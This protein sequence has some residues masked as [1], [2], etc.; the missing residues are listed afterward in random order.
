M[1]CVCAH[2]RMHAQVRICVYKREDTIGEKGEDID[3]VS[4]SLIENQLYMTLV[5]PLSREWGK[6]HS[7]L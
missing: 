7:E 6:E 2:A 4:Y 1:V 3:T 5:A